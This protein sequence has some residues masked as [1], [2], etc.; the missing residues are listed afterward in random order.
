MGELGSGLRSSFRLSEPL[1]VEDCSEVVLRRSICVRLGVLGRGMGEVSGWVRK[2]FPGEQQVPSFIISGKGTESFPILDIRQYTCVYDYDFEIPEV[3]SSGPCEPGEESLIHAAIYWV[4]SEVEMV[5]RGSDVTI[6]EW[7]VQTGSP[8]ISEGLRNG[9]TELALEVQSKITGPTG[10]LVIHGGGHGFVCWA[11]TGAQL[12][13]ELGR[14]RMG[15]G[16]GQE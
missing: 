16:I 12:M 6:W 3:K 15:A 5:L 10:S 8:F 7:M 11:R 1:P 9:T 14:L 4:N 13:Q 2:Q